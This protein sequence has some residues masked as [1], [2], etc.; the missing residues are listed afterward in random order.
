MRPEVNIM[1]DYRKM[2]YILCRAASEA[3]DAEPAAARQLL[4]KALYEAEDIYI[5]T[6]S[7]EE[8]A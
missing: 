2:Y 4:Q 7:D 6:C 3:I 8:K 5:A 1:T